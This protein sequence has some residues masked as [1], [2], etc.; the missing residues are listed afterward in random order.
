M[1]VPLEHTT[2]V[3]PIPIRNVLHVQSVTFAQ[4]NQAILRFA[5]KV[6]RHKRQVSNVALH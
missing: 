3:M 1:I 5:H 4:L 2:L 6:P